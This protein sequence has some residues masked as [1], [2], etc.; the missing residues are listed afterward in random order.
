MTSFKLCGLS[1]AAYVL[2]R[3]DEAKNGTK[4]RGGLGLF[5][6]PTWQHQ[7][8]CVNQIGRRSF[9]WF[10]LGFCWLTIRFESMSK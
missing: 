6:S 8:V 1:S 2:G 3:L 7:G 10:N 5:R 4:T 9:D